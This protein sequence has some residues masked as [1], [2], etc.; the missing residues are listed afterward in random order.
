MEWVGPVIGSLCGMLV[1]ALIMW[2]LVSDGSRPR[3]GSY[4]VPQPEGARPVL[5]PVLFHSKYCAS[6]YGSPCNCQRC[7]CPKGP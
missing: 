2:A 1:F 6:R 3:R 4:V 5:P 7:H